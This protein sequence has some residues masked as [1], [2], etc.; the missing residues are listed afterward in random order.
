[1]RVPRVRAGSAVEL[2]VLCTAWVAAQRE[3]GHEDF[4][5]LCFLELLMGMAGL[6]RFC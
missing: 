2:G 1:M 4:M 6:A 3:R 5:F